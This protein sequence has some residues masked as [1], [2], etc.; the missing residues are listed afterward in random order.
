[1]TRSPLQQATDCE[2]ACCVPE[3]RSP[4]ATQPTQHRRAVAMA[5]LPAVLVVVEEDLL[6]QLLKHH[7]GLVHCI[8]LRPHVSQ[9]AAHVLHETIQ[10]VV[11]HLQHQMDILQGTTTIISGSSQCRNDVVSLLPLDTLQLGPFEEH[12]DPLV[13]LNALVQSIDHGHHTVKTSQALEQL[14]HAVL[15]VL[16]LR[17]LHADHTASG[18]IGTYLG[19]HDSS[20]HHRLSLNAI[21]L[22]RALEELR[23]HIKMIVRNVHVVVGGSHLLHVVL[24]GTTESPGEVL[25]HLA[26]DLTLL[27]LGLLEMEAN[28]GVLDQLVVHRLH[29][30]LQ[31]HVTTIPLEQRLPVLHDRSVG[32]IPGSPQHISPHRLQRHHDLINQRI[33]VPSPKQRPAKIRQ[34]CIEVVVVN[35]KVLVQL[36][37]LLALVRFGP[38]Q[39]LHD[40]HRHARLDPVLILQQELLDTHICGTDVEELIHQGGDTLAPTKALEH[41]VLPLLHILP[42]HLHPHGESGRDIGTNGL[43][44]QEGIRNV[45]GLRTAF[46][47]HPPNDIQ[48]SIKVIIGHIHPVVH[49]PQVVG[50]VGHR[51]SE[52]SPHKLG[53]LFLN[54]GNLRL[55]L[56]EETPNAGVLQG[57]VVH[58][59]HHVGDSHLAPE[60][61]IHRLGRRRLLSFL[62]IVGPPVDQHVP[63]GC[64]QQNHALVH[65]SRVR[66]D[67]P[68]RC[69]AA[70]EEGV[71]FEVR[72]RHHGVDAV[73]GATIILDRST[74]HNCQVIS[75]ALLDSINL[76]PTEIMLDTFVHSEGLVQLVNEGL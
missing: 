56:L 31:V 28:P 58:G 32:G 48:D 70:G 53:H 62:H 19:N 71:E 18:H 15:G 1:M 49:G 47:Q 72:D 7:R 30:S 43:Q 25:V 63:P 42:G 11:I 54:G 67:R 22:G 24:H 12:V 46:L 75:L 26:A 16:L 36:S 52:D 74:K 33:L 40:V 23:H 60:S 20:V 10:V 37:E 66:P 14:V 64:L 4:Q 59:L 13:A 2:Q 39:H 51:P 57:L 50:V 38:P 68:Q 8:L 76:A 3:Q 69:G 45:L 5:Q 65:V 61:L 29:H 34:K 27:G 6:P 44:N 9:S 55:V 21:L 41:L 17:E 35:P 73:Q